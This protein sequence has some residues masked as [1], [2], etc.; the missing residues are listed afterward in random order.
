MSSLKP[1]EIIFTT[2]WNNLSVHC[3]VLDSL[4]LSVPAGSNLF[5]RVCCERLMNRNMCRSK[6]G[7]NHLSC[8]AVTKKSTICVCSGK[9]VHL[10]VRVYTRWVPATQYTLCDH[11]DFITTAKLSLCMTST[12][13]SEKSIWTIWLLILTWILYY[14]YSYWL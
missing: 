2:K 11:G 4:L 3:S 9:C 12:R 13:D 8:S 10:E 7:A 1:L 5:C 6:H 14:N